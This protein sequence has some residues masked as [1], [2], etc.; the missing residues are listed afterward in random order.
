MFRKSRSLP[1]K[2]LGV[3]MAMALL[4]AACGGDDDG[5]GD[6]E[7]A[8]E[9]VNQSNADEAEGDPVKGGTLVYGID[10][11]SANPWAPY[12]TS[13]ATSC[14][15]PLSMVSDTIFAVND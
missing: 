8:A 7:G 12:R 4:A 2:L 6:D 5:G 1:A 15:V 11:D 13:C 9:D 3:L 10:S 14:Y